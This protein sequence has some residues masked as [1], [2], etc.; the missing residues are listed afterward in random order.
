[1]LIPGIGYSKCCGTD[2]KSNTLNNSDTLLKSL[3][4]DLRTMSKQMIGG[5]G[6]LEKS[7]SQLQKD[8]SQYNQYLTTME[9][10]LASNNTRIESLE[11]QL[12]KVQQSQPQ[13]DQFSLSLIREFELRSKIK[14]NVILFG[15]PEPIENNKYVL[16][17]DE[18]FISD[19]FNYISTQSELLYDFSLSRVGKFSI[20]RENPRP[21]KLFLK[22]LEH[23]TNIIKLAK[24]SKEN[25]KLSPLFKDTITT[26]DTTKMQ[27]Q[28]F[29]ELKI[30]LINRM[31]NG[32]TNIAIR[33]IQGF[34][35]I[36]KI[37]QTVPDP[38]PASSN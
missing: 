13:S 6:K 24:T 18:Q 12:T 22:S 27:Q 19:F 8:L 14:N 31:D 17:K 3:S 15:I 7:V 36:V 2:S 34:P 21:L 30:A 10:N 1:M 5:F 37:H 38:I 9:V 4:Q 33:Y 35:K 26:A 25:L 29:K 11:S 20:A 16:E 23:A 32:E 28:Q